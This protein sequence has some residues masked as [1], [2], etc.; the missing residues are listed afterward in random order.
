MPDPYRQQYGFTQAPG[1]VQLNGKSAI[2]ALY[3]HGLYTW[4]SQDEY[5]IVAS[6]QHAAIADALNSAAT[7]WYFAMKNVTARRGHG[8]PLSEQHDSTHKIEYPQP[9]IATLCVPDTIDDVNDHRPI[10]FPLLLNANNRSR[11]DSIMSW[12]GPLGY[13]SVPALTK[14]DLR[15][16]SLMTPAGNTSE[17]YLKWIDLPE[18]EFRGSAIGAIIFEPKRVAD[19]SQPISVCNVAAGWGKSTLQV[20][21]NDY[22]SGGKVSS[23]PKSVHFSS[24]YSKFTPA[25]TGEMGGRVGF[26]YPDFPQVPI[27]I[28]STWAD[29]LSSPM[30][31]TSSTI[32][33]QLMQQQLFQGKA[34]TTA[35]VVLSGM[36]ANGLARIGFSSTLQGDLKTKSASKDN[37]TQI[38]GDY[39]LSGKGDVFNV[40]ASEAVDWTKLYMT[41]TLQGNAYNTIG[42][43]PKTAIAILMVY[44]MVAICHVVYAGWTGI[45]SSS[46][47]SIAEL[48]ALAMNSMPTTYLRNTCGGISEMH[49]FK[50]PVRILAAKDEEGEG[51]HLELVFGEIPDGKECK[52][53]SIEPNRAYGTMT[54][55]NRKQI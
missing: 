3:N 20:Q 23:T 15:R 48:T 51:E 26:E 25:G 16:S 54:K 7:L 8:N 4:S 1:S 38:D 34:S 28:A 27:T 22:A 53:S 2:R 13:R 31:N 18:E 24:Q 52:Q 10:K 35:S 50:L 5:I 36:I 30:R 6:T 47:D 32:F 46:W 14:H 44:C 33:N 41:S 37:S 19:H 40:N 9:Y 29:L 42:I 43:P 17:F 49:I 21:A 39:W 11:N 55:V 12:N 45:S